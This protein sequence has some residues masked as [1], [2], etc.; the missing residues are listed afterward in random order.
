MY[1][2]DHRPRR[3]Y[4]VCFRRCSG[5]HR[6]GEDHIGLARL[7]KISWSA[8]VIVTAWRQ[9]LREMVSGSLDGGCNISRV[10]LVVSRLSCGRSSVCWFLTAENAT[11]WAP[12]LVE[13]LFG[14]TNSNTMAGRLTELV[15]P[16]FSLSSLRSK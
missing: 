4:R 12:Q 3:Q 2:G 1:E 6:A 13:Q 9:S 11:L 10:G 8:F 5:Y 15:S 14:W 7:S 16:A